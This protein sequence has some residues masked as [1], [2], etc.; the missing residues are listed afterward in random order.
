MQ[1]DEKPDETAT[2][3][4]DAREKALSQGSNVVGGP[5]YTRGRDSIQ[6][7]AE[8]KAGVYNDGRATHD[9]GLGG[10]V[11][12]VDSVSLGWE[13]TALRLRSPLSALPPTLE[14]SD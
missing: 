1:H 5:Q 11:R 4:S 13:S 2:E 7:T 8:W 3:E 6:T 9:R 10:N 14:S 12:P